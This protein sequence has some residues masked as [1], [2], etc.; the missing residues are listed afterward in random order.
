MQL[1]PESVSLEDYLIELDVVDYSHSIIQDKVV[2]LFTDEQTEVEKVKKAFEFV[3]DHISHSWDIQ[4]T[5]VTC[6]A[7]EVLKNKEGICYAKSNLLAAL[8]RSAGIPTGFCYQ[9]LM[10]FDT[11]EKGY[12]LHTLNGVFL[13][14][15]NRWIRIDARGNK[16]GV[17]AE[18]SINEEKLAFSVQEEF[19]EKDYPV[20]YTKPNEKT[21]ATLRESTN[22][23]Q[24]YEHY[25]PDSL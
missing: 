12:S 25:L 3:R 16:P 23:V 17:K 1:V 9:R 20:I 14:S 15:L 24:M 2:E 11:P 13:H 4:S 10:L 18:F 19:E 8:L 22:A 5:K 6:K 7:S 21:I